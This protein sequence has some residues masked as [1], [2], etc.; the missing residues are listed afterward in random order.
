MTESLWNGWNYR[1]VQYHDGSGYGVHEV[2][3]DKD[4]KEVSMTAEPV[5]LVAET[6]EEICASILE[7]RLDVVR[8]PIFVE[9]AGWK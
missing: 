8:R 7:V 5:S 3:Y 9:P 2:Y 1:L 6:A 4:G